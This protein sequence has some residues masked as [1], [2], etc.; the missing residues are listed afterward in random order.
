M[1]EQYRLSVRCH[2]M[3]VCR[4]DTCLFIVY[5]YD[6]GP[7]KYSFLMRGH[8][9]KAL[10]GG[11]FDPAQS[12]PVV[13]NE[14]KSLRAVV[15][16]LFRTVRGSAAYRTLRKGIQRKMRTH[17]LALPLA[18][19]AACSLT[20]FA[21][22]NTQ[23]HATFDAAQANP[24]PAQDEAE[25][26]VQEPAWPCPKGWSVEANPAVE[27]SLSYVHESNNLAVSVTYIAN[28][29]GAGVSGQTYARVAAEQMNCQL[30]V[31]SNLIENAW[32]FDC[33]LEQVEAMV[34][35]EPGNLVLLA[36][37]GRDESTE[38][39]LEDFVRFLAYQ[40]RRQ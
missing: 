13:Y 9:T 4:E 6:K 38:S 14:D 24:A 39:Y 31:S 37:S 32:S 21:A 26:Q 27:N 7:V 33:P 16:P 17:A 11:R 20:A 25:A 2:R 30:P 34:Y 10:H 35:G 18:L 12:L 29:A 8:N 19:F 28:Q 23:V 1:A 22:D 40:A 15:P 5:G 3:F 36:I